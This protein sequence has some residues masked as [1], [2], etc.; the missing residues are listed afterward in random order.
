MLWDFSHGHVLAY[1]IGNSQGLMRTRFFL[2]CYIFSI[3]QFA[4]GVWVWGKVVGWV[5][6]KLP[7]V[8]VS[9]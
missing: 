2:Y 1:C 5:I 3:E 8:A 6:G 9:P 7:L 4:M